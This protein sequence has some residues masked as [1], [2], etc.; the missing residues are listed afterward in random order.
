MSKGR[1]RKRHNYQAKRGKIKGKK[2]EKTL[3]ELIQ[4]E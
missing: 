1:K 2:R 4:L 3:Q